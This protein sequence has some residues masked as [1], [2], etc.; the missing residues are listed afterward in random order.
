MLNRRACSPQA[1]PPAG[2][3]PSVRPPS[4]DRGAAAMANVLARVVARSG[5]HDR[6]RGGRIE[7]VI[8]AG[9]GEVSAMACMH[10]GDPL[11][12]AFRPRRTSRRS[13]A[14][15][16]TCRWRRPGYPRR[17]RSWRRSGRPIRRRAGG[18]RTCPRGAAPTLL[19]GMWRAPCPAARWCLTTIA[20]AGL[21]WAVE[22]PA[23][24]ARLAGSPG[25]LDAPGRGALISAGGWA[26]DPC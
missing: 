20:E 7:N 3:A 16:A 5:S 1:L 24:R 13:V 10:A 23:S 12:Q 22:L 15:S 4:R 2:I 26:A 14:T 11:L 21:P 8:G 19:L 17:A 6:R 18:S 25:P 9:C